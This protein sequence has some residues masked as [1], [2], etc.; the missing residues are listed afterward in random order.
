MLTPV[1]ASS[2]RSLCPCSACLVIVPPAQ[3]VAQMLTIPVA[4]GLCTLTLKTKPAFSHTKSMPDLHRSIGTLG[5]TMGFFGGLSLV[6][7]GIAVAT[8]NKTFD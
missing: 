7:A 6:A 5:R 3:F 8:R 1:L 2:S 4:L